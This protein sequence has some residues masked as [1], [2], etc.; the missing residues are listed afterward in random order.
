MRWEKI[1]LQALMHLGAREGQPAV[2]VTVVG[3][4]AYRHDAV[5]DLEEMVFKRRGSLLDPFA[6]GRGVWAWPPRQRQ[7][8]GG[9]GFLHALPC[10]AVTIPAMT[11]TAVAT[12]TVASLPARTVMFKAG[13][14]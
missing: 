3:R 1:M 10:G 2:Q 12:V 11:S 8:P 9:I 4:G 14:V 13:S 7:P 6:E 5:I